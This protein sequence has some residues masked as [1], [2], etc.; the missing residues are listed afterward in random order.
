[1]TCMVNAITDD[2]QY[3]IAPSLQQGFI[4]EAT[5]ELL[6]YGV[7]TFYRDADHSQKKPVYTVSGP[8]DDPI[9]TELPNPLTLSAIGTFVDPNNNQDIIPYYKPFDD[10]GNVDLYYITV[11]SSDNVLQ[12][13]RDHYPTVNV[14]SDDTITQVENFIPNG[15]FLMHLDLPDNG[16]IPSASTVGTDTPIAYG[17]WIFLQD[18]ATS[19]QDFVTFTRYNA[20]IDEPEQNPRY[21]CRI[22]CTLANPSDS[23]K[24][25]TVFFQDVNFMQGQALTLQFTA[26]SND[27]NDHNVTILVKKN[28]GSGGSPTTYDTIDTVTVTPEI[29]NF[30]INFTMSSNA[31]Q[32]LGTGNDDNVAVIFRSPIPSTS[33]ISYT[34]MMLVAGTFAALTYPPITPEQD[35]AFALPASL[36]YP[37]YDGSDNGKF[38]KASQS[39]QNGTQLGFV[40]DNAVPTGTIIMSGIQTTTPPEG[41]LYCDGTEY[42]RS[43][44]LYIDLFNVIGWGWGTGVNGFENLDFSSDTYFIGWNRYDVTQPIPDAGT[45]GFIYTLIQ[46]A[47][48][49]VQQQQYYLQVLPGSSITAGSYFVQAVNT[50]GPQVVQLFW[51]TVDGVGTIP[52][53]PYDVAVQIDILS[54]DTATQVKDKLI[55]QANGFFMVPDMRGFFPRF[56]DNGAGRDPY[57][58]SR[59]QGGGSYPGFPFIDPSGNAGDEVFSI[60]ASSNLS[61]DHPD[62]SGLIGPAPYPFVYIRNVGNGTGPNRVQVS[63]DAS[64]YAIDQALWADPSDAFGAA[65]S[66]ESRPLNIYVNGFIKT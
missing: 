30:L 61:H 29:Q 49:G 59:L 42:D 27:G 2:S 11:Y 20:P 50:T 47:I 40:Y 52:N 45:S 36:D 57:S 64:F 17:G 26:Y 12:F 44:P 8:P 3:M 7:V 35:K 31:G 9:F 37:S 21:A 14:S 10:D 15:Q 48:A 18:Q 34:D 66:T 33:D 13:T 39:T 5:G 56:W 1:M 51:M 53:V 6:S 24:D 58:A 41:Y 4:N 16:E 32:T 62:P 23:Q 54:T 46:P 38:I 28:Y 22:Q 55:D 43:D 25:L 65:T 19:A 60:Q 63:T